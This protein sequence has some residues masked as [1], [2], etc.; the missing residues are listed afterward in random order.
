MSSTETA[1]KLLTKLSGFL[2]SCAIPAGQLPQRRKLLRLHEAILRGPQIPW[3]LG[4]FARATLNVLEQA[5]ILDRH[6]RLICKG[7]QQ[8]NGGFCELARCLAPDH[9]RAHDLARA[10]GRN[11]QDATIALAHD[12]LVDRRGGLTRARPRLQREKITQRECR[13]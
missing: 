10:E 9:E 3:R 13:T 7:L 1:E 2:I 4:Q 5:R 8:L 12:D 11:D 6:H